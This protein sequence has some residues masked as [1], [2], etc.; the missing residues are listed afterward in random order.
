MSEYILSNKAQQDLSDIWEYTRDVW[1]ERQ[2][3]KYYYMLLDICQDLA[4]KK[5]LGKYYS[6]LKGDIWGFKAGS[7]IILFR[8][9]SA[10]HIEITRIVHA[11]MDLKKQS[12]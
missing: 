3:E 11:G 2:A 5:L 1:S 12:I 7:H 9:Q 10:E 6:Q 4:E 8:Q